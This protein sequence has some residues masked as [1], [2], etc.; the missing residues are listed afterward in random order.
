[1]LTLAKEIIVHG[2]HI[3]LVDDADYPLL[4]QFQWYLVKGY[5]YRSEWR[6]GKTKLIPMHHDLLPI[7]PRG[8][9][10]DHENRNR[11]DNRRKNLRI[12]TPTQNSA[13]S[14]APMRRSK[15]SRYKGVRQHAGSVLWTAS[16]GVDGKYLH[17]GSYKDET[18]AALAYDSAARFYF[19]EFA[20]TNFAGTSS[21]D[22]ATLR[23]QA[24]ELFKERTTS[25]FV[26]VFFNT[27]RNKWQAYLKRKH[28]G[29][30]AD[31]A[32]ALVAR[33]QAEASLSDEAL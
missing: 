32:S 24:R 30:F 14:N 18:V 28:L 13:N 23:R 12:C 2:G 16:I 8:M 17:L 1:M 25:R 21:A 26:G 29:Y 22:A 19:A 20:G 27:R 4:S 10:R 15:T 5:A 33:Q 7:I 6:N 9:R 3:A 31:E 11:L